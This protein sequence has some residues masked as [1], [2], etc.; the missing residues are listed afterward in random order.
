MSLERE[1]FL[2]QEPQQLAE[3]QQLTEP[4]QLVLDKLKNM[5]LRKT[6]TLVL[7]KREGHTK[8][9]TQILNDLNSYEI[10]IE[11]EHPFDNTCYKKCHGVCLKRFDKSFWIYILTGYRKHV[12]ITPYKYPGKVIVVSFVF[13]AGLFKMLRANED[14]KASFYGNIITIL[15]QLLGAFLLAKDADYVMIL[16]KIAGFVVASIILVGIIRNAE[17]NIGL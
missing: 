5:R 7:K 9:W 17:G 1:H 2:T 8:F 12:V 11:K 4:Q 10:Q 14:G 16:P 15:A 6:K 3:S 13:I